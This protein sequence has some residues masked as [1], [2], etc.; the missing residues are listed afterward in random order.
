MG[1]NG[2]CIGWVIVVDCGIMRRILYIILPVFLSVFGEFLLKIST[3]NQ[4]F[5]FTWGHIILA[6]TSPFIWGGIALIMGAAILWIIGMRHFQLSFMYPFLSLNY[7]LVVLGS[8]WL[9]N[10]QVQLSR[11][12]SIGL[13]MI[14]LLIISQSRH[15]STKE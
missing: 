12:V 8:E 2:D 14:G 1:G 15:S 3:Q 5:R 11:Y 10:E 4:P 9:L 6:V 7:G 13:I